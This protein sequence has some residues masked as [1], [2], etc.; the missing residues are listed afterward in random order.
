MITAANVYTATDAT[1]PRTILDILSATGDLGAEVVD[2]LSIEQIAEALAARGGEPTPLPELAGILQRLHAE[3][4]LRRTKGPRGENLY[5]P[6]PAPEED[7]VTRLERQ[8]LQLRQSL[9]ILVGAA[10]RAYAGAT[11]NER[12]GGTLQE[13]K[14]ATDD[15][16]AALEA[17]A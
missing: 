3:G 9:A 16:R 11:P 6:V 1:D 17:T 14:D 10:T 4:E 15:A 8:N 2:G 13:L 12:L 5:A 7:Q